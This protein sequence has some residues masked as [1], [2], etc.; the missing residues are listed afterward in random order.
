MLSGLSE[1]MFGRFFWVRST[2]IFVELFKVQQPK[3][4]STMISSWLKKF[5]FYRR[6]KIN[7][8]CI[9]VLRTLDCLIPG[10]STNIKGVLHPAYHAADHSMNLSSSV[11]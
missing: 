9:T 1:R 7:H 3:V 2:L 5:Y 6:Q 10:L 8:L 4:R 11:H